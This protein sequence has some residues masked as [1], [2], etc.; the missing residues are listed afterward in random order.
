MLDLTC[1]PARTAGLGSRQRGG[2]PDPHQA[3]LR[4]RTAA[5]ASGGRGAWRRSGHALRPSR[6][7]G[8][9]SGCGHAGLPRPGLHHPARRIAPGPRHPQRGMAHRRQVHRTDHR[10]R[11]G[12]RACRLR[13]GVACDRGHPAR[14]WWRVGVRGA[15]LRRCGDRDRAS[16]TRCQLHRRPSRLPAAIRRLHGH[17]GACLPPRRS[18]LGAVSGQLRRPGRGVAR[19]LPGAGIPDRSMVPGP[20]GR[21]DV[22]PCSKRRLAG[23][24]AGAARGAGRPGR[25]W[26]AAA[27][28]HDPLRPRFRRP[29]HAV[30]VA[31]A[32]APIGQ[33][34][35][36]YYRRATP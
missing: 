30:V 5:L 2:L 19:P 33:V 26:G 3:S 16:V 29:D 13:P 12:A 18:P 32:D 23:G 36:L 21:G 1:P 10:P 24:G 9:G 4:S 22:R 25:G 6:A 14:R 17:L 15:G 27:R 28:L 7:L 20:P 35:G 11:C 31:G 34:A 8:P